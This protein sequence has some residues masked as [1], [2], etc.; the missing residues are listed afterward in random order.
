MSAP[1]SP[2]CRGPRPGTVVFGIVTDGL[3]NSSQEFDRATIKAMIEDQES[4]Y[5]W[6]FMYLGAN[7]DAIEVGAGLGVAADRAL[8]YTGVNAAPAMAAYSRA[9]SSLRAAAAAGSSI[10]Q[11]RLGAA[12][13]V[14]ER[15]DS[16]K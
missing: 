9:T 15:A 7:Q 6:T 3:E 5:S 11:A 8:T 13:T 10:D 14:E 4:T 16:T 12:Y 2:P 1:I